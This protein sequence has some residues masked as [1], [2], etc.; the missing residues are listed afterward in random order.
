M[1]PGSEPSSCRVGD[2]VYGSDDGQVGTV[3]A[4][5]AHFLSVEHGL[6]QKEELRIPRSAINAC[7]GGTVV[8]TV[9]KHAALYQRWEPLPSL[10]DAGQPPPS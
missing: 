3:I 7:E 2:P 1:D 4:V 6:L 5:D 8:L 9:P 10:D